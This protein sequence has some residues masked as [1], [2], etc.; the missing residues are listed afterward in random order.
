[1]KKVPYLLLWF[2][3]K[4]YPKLSL[5]LSFHL[6]L[7]SVAQS[8]EHSTGDQEVMGSILMRPATFFH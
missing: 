8:H 1:M 3:C 4:Y 7:V 6:A 5:Q 2:Q